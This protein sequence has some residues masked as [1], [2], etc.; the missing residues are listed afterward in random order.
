M[1]NVFV[2]KDGYDVYSSLFI[3][4]GMFSAIMGALCFLASSI[5]GT[6]LSFNQWISILKQFIIARGY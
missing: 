1:K 2:H 5:S 4:I 3:F 6:T